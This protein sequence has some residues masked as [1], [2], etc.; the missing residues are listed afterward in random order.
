MIHGTI[1]DTPDDFVVEE[2]P[3]Y[4]PCGEGDHLYVRL[5][6]SGMTTRDVVRQ[7]AQ[8]FQMSPDEI[9]Y[10]GLKDKVACVT[11]SFSLPLRDQG[12][13]EVSRLIED[14]STLQVLQVKAHRNKL[15]RGHLLGNKFCIVVQTEDPEAVPKVTEIA[16][17][18]AQQG[19]PNYYGEQRFGIQHDNAARGRELLLSQRRLRG[20]KDRLMLSA[21]QSQLFNQWLARRIEIG[22]FEQLLRGDIAKKTETGGIFVVEDVATEQARLEAKEITYTGPIFGAKMRA[23]MHDAGACE[24]EILQEAGLDETC[25]RRHRLMGSRRVARLFISDLAINPH[26]RGLEFKFTLPKGAYATALLREF[27]VLIGEPANNRR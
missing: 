22:N 24:T 26:E 1:K 15:K 18:L 12:E 10:A 25:F 8:L 2:I 19:L 17:R 5:H 21:Y 11:Q 7:L 20:W 16:A 27:Y 4:E 14:S 9:G 3:L 6:R 13:T 23:A